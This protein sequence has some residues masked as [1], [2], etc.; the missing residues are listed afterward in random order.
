MTLRNKNI[1]IF[2]F[3]YMAHYVVIDGIGYKIIVIILVWIFNLFH[4]IYLFD[5]KIMQVKN[6]VQRTSNGNLTNLFLKT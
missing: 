5:V 6:V 4:L 1:A 3:N 2:D